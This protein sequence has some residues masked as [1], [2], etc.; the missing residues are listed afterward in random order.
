MAI[1]RLLPTGTRG[2]SI[3][4]SLVVYPLRG[5][6]VVRSWPKKRGKKLHPK[7]REQVEWFKEAVQLA[8][9]AD[10]ESQRRAIEW[11]KGT[12]LY[13]R[14]LIVHAMA[15]NLLEFADE[16]DN[17]YKKHKFATETAV[18]QGAR[19][20]RTTNI[21]IPSNTTFRINWQSPIL[22]T[23]PIWSPSNPDRLTVPD[24]VSIVSVEAGLQSSV[25]QGGLW[26]H[27]IKDAAGTLYSGAGSEFN[28]FRNIAASTGPIPVS[29]GDYFVV[30]TF[31]VGARQ[32][33]AGSSVFFSMTLLE[34]A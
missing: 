4:G 27:L 3:R 10:P 24:G 14:D 33:T 2:P 17:V 21:T 5:R 31:T 34:V 12:G 1:G 28:G 7:V 8:K 15:G 13:P 19:V 29:P 32:L 11:S 23:T 22:Q 18:F 6:L 30:D 26:V 16:N 20:V 9:Y 25:T